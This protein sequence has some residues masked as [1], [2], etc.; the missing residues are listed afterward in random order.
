MSRCVKF[1]TKLVFCANFLCIIQNLTVKSSGG[2]TD[3]LVEE[4]GIR[5]LIV[6]FLLLVCFRRSAFAVDKFLLGFVC[7]QCGLYITKLKFISEL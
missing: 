1:R 5:H 3:V 2:S 4:L 7:I 6:G